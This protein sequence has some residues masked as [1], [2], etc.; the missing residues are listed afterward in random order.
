MV[1]AGLIVRRNA[2][3]PAMVK[4]LGQQEVYFANSAA[5]VQAG[6]FTLTRRLGFEHLPDTLAA[7]E[8]HWADCGI[9]AAA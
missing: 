4:R 8:R 1:D 2:Y 6:V 3:R 9:A 5:L 7:L